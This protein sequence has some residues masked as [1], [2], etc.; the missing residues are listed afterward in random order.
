MTKQVLFLRFSSVEN[1]NCWG[2]D[3]S[4]AIHNM[5][6]TDEIYIVSNVIRSVSKEAALYAFDNKFVF[7]LGV[8]SDVD[9][10]KDI[11][12]NDC[13]VTAFNVPLD[14][15]VTKRPQSITAYNCY[16]IN[17]D[18]F[19]EER[20]PFTHYH[21]SLDKKL[22]NLLT[23]SDIEAYHSCTKS[24]DFDKFMK[25]SKSL[26]SLFAQG[27]QVDDIFKAILNLNEVH[28]HHMIFEAGESAQN[29]IRDAASHIFEKLEKCIIADDE[30]QKKS[31]ED[32]KKEKENEKLINEKEKQLWSAQV[33]KLANATKNILSGY[34][35]GHSKVANNDNSGSGEANEEQ[36]VEEEENAPT[37]ENI[38]ELAGDDFNCLISKS[39]LDRSKLAVHPLSRRSD[40]TILG[41]ISSKINSND[42]VLNYNFW[43]LRSVQ[44]SLSVYRNALLSKSSN[45][46]DLKA[47]ILDQLEVHPVSIKVELPNA[48]STMESKDFDAKIHPCEQLLRYFLSFRTE[49]CISDFKNLLS[50]KMFLK[51]AHN[52]N[53]NDYFT[54]FNEVYYPDFVRAINSVSPGVENEMLKKYAMLFSSIWF[55]STLSQRVRVKAKHDKNELFISQTFIANETLTYFYNLIQKFCYSIAQKIKDSSNE[56]FKTE[57]KRIQRLLQDEPTSEDAGH[58][59]H[60]STE[61]NLMRMDHTSTNRKSLM[62]LLETKVLKPHDKVLLCSFE[63][64]SLLPITDEMIDHYVKISN[65]RITL[66]AKQSKLFKKNNTLSTLLRDSYSKEDYSVIDTVSA[67]QAYIDHLFLDDLENLLKMDL[68]SDANI[69]N[70]LSKVAS[71]LSD[72]QSRI[73]SNVILSNISSQTSNVL[74]NLVSSATEFSNLKIHQAMKTAWINAKKLG[75]PASIRKLNML[76]AAVTLPIDSDFISVQFAANHHENERFSIESYLSVP[77][78]R[79]N[80]TQE[81]A[82]ELS[83]LLTREAV[84]DTL[85]LSQTK[86]GCMGS[87]SLAQLI[88]KSWCESDNSFKLSDTLSTIDRIKRHE[89][90]ESWWLQPF[91]EGH[92]GTETL[93][94]CGYTN[95]PDIDTFPFQ[96]KINHLKIEKKDEL[97]AYISAWSGDNFSWD[98]TPR[99]S[100]VSGVHVDKSLPWFRAKLQSELL[101]S[102]VTVR[103]LLDN[104]ESYSRADPKT[105]LPVSHHFILKIGKN[106]Q[107]S[108]YIDENKLSPLMLPFLLKSGT[109][110]I[111]NDLPKLI[112]SNDPSVFL[113][114]P[115]YLPLFAI[116]LYNGILKWS[117]YCFDTCIKSNM[118]K[119]KYQQLVETQ[120]YQIDFLRKHF[121]FNSLPKASFESLNT[122]LE[123]LDSDV[124]RIIQLH[125]KNDVEFLALF[126]SAQ[127]IHSKQNSSSVN[128]EILMLHQTH[129]FSVAQKKIAQSIPGWRCIESF[130]RV[131]ASAITSNNDQLTRLSNKYLSVPPYDK[132]KVKDISRGIVPPCLEFK[133]YVLS[134]FLNILPHGSI[135]FHESLTSLKNLVGHL[136]KF[137]VE[138]T[139]LVGWEFLPETSYDTPLTCF[140]KSESSEYSGYAYNG[141]IA[142]G[143]SWNS[144]YNLANLKS[145]IHPNLCSSPRK[146]SKSSDCHFV[147]FARSSKALTE[148]LIRANCVSSNVNDDN[149]PYTIYDIEAFKTSKKSIEE[150][151]LKKVESAFV[152]FPVSLLKESIS[153]TLDKIV[154]DRANQLEREMETTFSTECD[155]AERVIHGLFPSSTPMVSK[156]NDKEDSFNFLPVEFEV[157]TGLAVVDEADPFH[158]QPSSSKFLT[159]LRQVSRSL[160]MNNYGN[161]HSDLY[162]KQQFASG[163]A[164]PGEIPSIQDLLLL[165]LLFNFRFRKTHRSF[166]ASS[167]CTTVFDIHNMKLLFAPTDIRQTDSIIRKI[168]FN[169]PKVDLLNPSANCIHTGNV[170]AKHVLQS[171]AKSH[172]L[173]TDSF[174]NTKEF[175]TE[176]VH[177]LNKHLN[178]IQPLTSKLVEENK[179]LYKSKIIELFRWMKSPN[180]SL[181][182]RVTFTNCVYQPFISR[183]ISVLCE[184][185]SKTLNG[186]TDDFDKTMAAA[187]LLVNSFTSLFDTSNNNFSELFFGVDLIITNGNYAFLAIYY[188]CMNNPAFADQVTKLRSLNIQ[189]ALNYD[190]IRQNILCGT[191][192]N[193]CK[194]TYTSTKPDIDN[195]ALVNF[196]NKQEHIDFIA[197]NHRKDGYFRFMDHRLIKRLCN[198]RILILPHWFKDVQNSIVDCL[199]QHN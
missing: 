4:A 100:Q 11:E 47:S 76:L 126:M 83:Q 175:V 128:D 99:L 16:N 40:E 104:Y 34:T 180:H 117:E 178:I 39:L 45:P 78:T 91:L 13:K 23:T 101:G 64:T 62:L 98:E 157:E 198:D 141:L 84:R 149:K 65:Q 199:Q 68:N 72:S 88:R 161:F 1:T 181:L 92:Y 85:K 57:L 112:A 123:V 122:K 61:L 22:N 63:L 74:S 56:T 66:E 177:L 10:F 132:K 29:K 164:N 50:L 19:L 163:K 148:S 17:I 143:N 168:L 35:D 107:G 3:I 138:K 114:N 103:E 134:N 5:K 96:L 160:M 191:I 154:Y 51:P 26:L 193:P 14:S 142:L 54:Y 167:W 183:M 18:T 70:A 58:V 111:E 94:V 187:S 79:L 127:Q 9:I 75:A 179:K 52:W 25:H 53:S 139:D 2:D 110:T 131:S 189:D 172:Q 185:C 166:N 146:K 115:D 196:N 69:A 86:K 43:A 170:E 153:H 169:L 33:R 95:E 7:N 192:Y 42:C 116:L 36:A 32:E 82:E 60:K 77:E 12:I 31:P 113:K 129:N 15:L 38:N 30:K 44:K 155:A 87:L 24:C 150:V 41:L 81:E 174:N 21:F 108:S 173:I 130:T 144:C 28:D 159:V 165:R 48:F 171:I 55:M 120:K 73:S 89:D 147:S 176:T 8:P 106:P 140:G 97:T 145:Y 109:L 190:R 137:G 195:H 133:S 49:A 186:E 46:N 71:N 182:D 162:L 105:G 158:K 125:F 124:N 121:G 67:E 20:V 156:A 194:V 184:S 197:N 27:C 93:G 152:N 6:D 119:I 102:V 37:L 80:L 135:P 136:L 151:M 90:K 59:L 188:S 118:K